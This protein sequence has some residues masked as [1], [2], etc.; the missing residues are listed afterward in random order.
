MDNHLS[1]TSFHQITLKNVKNI[2]RVAE[3]IQTETPE[4]LGAV[5][6]VNSKK[7]FLVGE[8]PVIHGFLFSS[9]YLHMHH[10]MMDR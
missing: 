5:D 4:N 8:L 9:R 2:T 6:G 10:M 1:F 3:G 7:S